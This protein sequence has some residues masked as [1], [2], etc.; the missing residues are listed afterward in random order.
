MKQSALFYYLINFNRWYI[1][2]IKR[3][4]SRVLVGGTAVAVGLQEPLW[5]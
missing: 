3:R 1:I 4:L 5:Q 2:N